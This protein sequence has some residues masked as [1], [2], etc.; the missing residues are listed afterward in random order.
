MGHLSFKCRSNE[1]KQQFRKPQTNQNNTVDIRATEVF[2]TNQSAKQ[3]N[4]NKYKNK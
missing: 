4:L 2:T 3:K 1:Q